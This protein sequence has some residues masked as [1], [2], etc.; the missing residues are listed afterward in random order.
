MFYVIDDCLCLDHI[1]LN[2]F[3][4]CGNPKRPKKICYIKEDS[5]CKDTRLSQTEKYDN[6]NWMKISVAACESK[7]NIGKTS[8]IYKRR[9]GLRGGKFQPRSLT[10]LLL[11]KYNLCNTMFRM[12]EKFMQGRRRPLYKLERAM[13]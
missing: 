4:N 8:Y 9:G 7:V 10:M 11:T 2:G 3:G 5:K 1:S 12:G 13:L 6:G